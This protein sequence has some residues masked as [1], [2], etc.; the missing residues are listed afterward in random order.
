V[1][2]VTTPGIL[3]IA[4]FDALPEDDERLFELHEGELVEM[5]FPVSLHSRLQRRIAKLLEMKLGTLGEVDIELPFQVANVPRQT[6]RRADIAF[7]THERWSQVPWNRLVEG[8]PDLIVEVVSPSNSVPKLNRD[9]RFFLAN[10]ARE[11]WV[12]DPETQT[13]SV[14][15]QDHTS[16]EY[17]P[18][19]TI[20]LCF[21]EG[22]LA[23]AD[24]FQGL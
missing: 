16:R 20:P 14:R 15:R 6:K 17:E 3:T 22:S 4:E 24:V 13:I 21:G 9:A 23:V 2:T 5:T 8:V 1:S 10:G 11:F 18:G 12:V 19:D 7:V